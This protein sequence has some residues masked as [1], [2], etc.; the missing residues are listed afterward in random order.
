MFFLKFKIV[1]QSNIGIIALT[2]FL[3]CCKIHEFCVCTQSGYQQFRNFHFRKSVLRSNSGHKIGFSKKEKS[4]IRSKNSQKMLE[5]SLKMVISRFFLRSVYFKSACI[6]MG[7]YSHTPL[8]FDVLFFLFF[9][10]LPS[11]LTEMFKKS[12]KNT[13]T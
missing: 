9:H 5:F 7:G 2:A 6:H 4:E 13:K 1:F 11:Y 8:I 3:F 12:R 10:Q